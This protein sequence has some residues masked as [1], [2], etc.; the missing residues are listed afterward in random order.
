MPKGKRNNRYCSD[1]HFSSSCQNLT[2]TMGIVL[3]DARLCKC[4]CY[5]PT[6]SEMQLRVGKLA[7][8]EEEESDTCQRQI[9][10]CYIGFG[11]MGRKV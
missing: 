11:S 9:E 4:I 6:M 2:K 3:N 5:Y 7:T 1:Q 10:I 8:G